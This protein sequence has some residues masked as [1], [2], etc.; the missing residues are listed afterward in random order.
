MGIDR[1]AITD[2]QFNADMDYA[3]KQYAVRAVGELLA[4]NPGTTT[5][6]LHQELM[7]RAEKA[8]EASSFGH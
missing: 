4:E 7:G 2:P 6:E 8:R 1:G 3:A 5:A